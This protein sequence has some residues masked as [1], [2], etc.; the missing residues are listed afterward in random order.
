MKKMLL[1]VLL[2]F[3]ASGYAQ[4][5]IW[6]PYD[7]LEVMWQFSDTTD[8]ETPFANVHIDTAAAGNIWQIGTPNKTVFTGAWS[9]SNAIVTDTVNTYP[10]NNYSYFD[11]YIGEFNLGPEFRWSLFVDMHHR[12]HTDTL[13]DGG[14]ISVSYDNGAT[15][16]NIINDWASYFCGAPAWQNYNLYNQTQTLYNG[17]RGFS[18]NSSGWVYTGFAW[19]GCPVAQQN[20]SGGISDTTILRFSFV[21]DSIDNQKDG[22]I[23]DQLRAYV[24]F[25]GSN[26][27]DIGLGEPLF[28]LAPNPAQS[29]AQVQV[30]RPCHVI[31]YTLSNLNGQML[32]QET[33]YQTD[34]F[35]LYLQDLP[36]GV[37]LLRLIA[38]GQYTQTQKLILR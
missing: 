28:K 16:T 1:L 32:R 5:E 15:F 33:A 14:F 9:G 38:D 34:A 6:P 29:Q 37:Y 3:S 27:P 11:I 22:W 13:T 2:V 24:C 19:H 23:I 20:R 25:L 4:S 7:C 31:D 8:F 35:T 12:F 26:V 30:S 17:E 10:T 18:G 36:P 21:S